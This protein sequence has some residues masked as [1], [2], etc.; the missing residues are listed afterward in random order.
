MYYNKLENEEELYLNTKS[1]LVKED[2]REDIILILTNKRLII[3][4]DIENNQMYKSYL[5]KKR[6]RKVEEKYM[7]MEFKI[8]DFV[9]IEV[10]R[11]RQLFILRG[12]N[13][14]V[15]DDVKVLEKIKDYL[16]ITYV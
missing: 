6:G 1:F 4:I 12:G 2:K 15:I 5:E 11:D 10:L 9:R 14:L 13:T 7:N 8:E 16:E 3:L